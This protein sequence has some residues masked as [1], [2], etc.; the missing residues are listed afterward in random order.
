MAVRGR[1]GPTAKNSSG[2]GWH[3]EWES[4]QYDMRNGAR[5][6]R[7]ATTGGQNNYFGVRGRPIRAT[8]IGRQS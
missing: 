8:N 6:Q 1:Y 2:T 4:G 5:G 3:C 7:Y